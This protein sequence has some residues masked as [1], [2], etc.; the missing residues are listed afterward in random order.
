MNIQRENG[1][2]K[3]N[4]ISDLLIEHYA[5][6]SPCNWGVIIKFSKDFGK[7]PLNGIQFYHDKPTNIKPVVKLLRKNGFPVLN[8]QNIDLNTHII[9]LFSHSNEN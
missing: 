5:S 9:T 6:K 3:I 4:E 7:C 2:L 8:V 1:R